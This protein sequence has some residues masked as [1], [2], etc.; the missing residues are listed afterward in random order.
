MRKFS[1]RDQVLTGIGTV[2]VG[3]LLFFG[4]KIGE[5]LLNLTSTVAPSTSFSTLD[6]IFS[7]LIV[8]GIIVVIYGLYALRKER[9]EQPVSSQK[10]AERPLVVTQPIT[11]QSATMH[12]TRTAIRNQ[13]FRN[14]DVHLDGYSWLGCRFI[15][16]SLLV[17]KGDFDTVSCT[18][19]D[20][21][22]VFGPDAMGVLRAAVMMAPDLL[23]KVKDD[24]IEHGNRMEPP[25]TEVSAQQPTEITDRERKDFRNG[26]AEEMYSVLKRFTD[27]L[28]NFNIDHLIWSSK[29]EQSKATIL[30][31]DDYVVLRSFYDALEERNRYF[32]SRHGFDLATLDPLNR[33]CVEALSEAYSEVTWLKV[34]FETD[35]LLSEA[36]KNVGLL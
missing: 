27:P 16:C 28:N 26:V 9:T 2:I 24:L 34:S 20:C 31:T 5:R 29:A 33:K 7:G 22:P 6:L 21:N 14:E 12:S 4:E 13:T 15:E 36:R 23:S 3:I 25:H 17:N 10:E 11:P 35:T 30:G 8:I 32:V 19:T 18:F 1:L